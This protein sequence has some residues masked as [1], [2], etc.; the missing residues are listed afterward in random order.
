MLE[1]FQSFEVGATWATVGFLF[2]RSRSDLHRFRPGLL[3]RYADASLCPYMQETGDGEA[4]DPLHFAPSLI[5]AIQRFPRQEIAT[6]TF[7]HY[8]CMAEGQDSGAFAADLAQAQSIA[9][10]YGIEVR[11]IVFPLNQH[12]S[13]YDHLLLEHGI[14]AYRGNPRTW[15]WGEPTRERLN[16][17]FRRIGRFTDAYVNVS[18]PYLAE[19]GDVLQPNGLANVP[20]SCPLRPYSRRLRW[21][22]G[23]RARRLTDAIEKAARTGRIFHLWWHPHNFGVNTDENLALL[24]RALVTFDRCRQQY[25]M[26][27]MTMA[28]VAAECRQ[29]DVS[30]SGNR[31]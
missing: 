14:T 26:R 13:K 8:H 1:L 9:A 31:P 17:P 23:L 27:S 6:H 24:R 4:D 7:S 19:W 2:A 10:G 21:L 5:E 25:G 12:N 15:M 3:P 28:E 11:S 22:E 16:S 30:A 29:A 20:A 18:G